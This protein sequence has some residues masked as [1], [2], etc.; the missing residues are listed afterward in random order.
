MKNSFNP[1]SLSILTIGKVHSINS[2]LFAAK[3]SNIREYIDINFKYAEMKDLL[4]NLKVFERSLI[5]RI[6]LTNEQWCTLLLNNYADNNGVPCTIVFREDYAIK[7]KKDFDNTKYENNKYKKII[8]EF[9]SEIV[10]L[11]PISASIK[12]KSK[13]ILNLESNAKNR[14]K[15]SELNELCLKEWIDNEFELKQLIDKTLNKINNTT[16]SELSN[17]LKQDLKT[18][19]V[20]TLTNQQKA[21]QLLGIETD[22]TLIE[23]YNKIIELPIDKTHG[24][25]KLEEIVSHEGFVEDIDVQNGY[26][27]T[28]F[29]AVEKIDVYGNKTITAGDEILVSVEM[30]I[31]Q[32]SSFISSFNNGGTVATL[33]NTKKAGE[34]KKDFSDIKYDL[35]ERKLSEFK[36]SIN[37]TK[38]E[39]MPYYKK[40]KEATK[41]KI[42]VK[43]VREI[44]INYEQFYNKFIS[45]ISHS[46]EHLIKE[47]LE[48]N[49]SKRMD[50]M[51][52]VEKTIKNIG[53]EAFEQKVEDS[54]QQ[55]KLFK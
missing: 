47:A 8:D 24:V 26:R 50:F 52:Q 18:G 21:L 4:G 55:I 7:Y 11:F 9:N 34:I 22:F 38:D 45:N 13:E 12:R 36:D 10:K 1:N 33:I 17:E 41:K 51:F 40:N 16:Q 30:S 37:Q 29:Q 49:I 23:Q 28:L 3:T 39:I 25:L 53:L 44:E 6:S 31:S 14:K 46:L 20:S 19:F 2:N 35:F 42:G 54:N 32:F 43:K 48:K 5:D 27:L 15:L